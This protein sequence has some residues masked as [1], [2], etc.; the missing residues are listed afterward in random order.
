SN[1]IIQF[2]AIQFCFTKTLLF[3]YINT[4]RSSKIQI[5]KINRMG[6]NHICLTYFSI[7]E[8]S[9]SKFTLVTALLDIGRGNWWEYRRT[10]ENYYQYLDNILHLNVD[11]VIFLDDKSADYIYKRRRGLGFEQK[12]KII[13]ISF[14]E[15]PFY[16]YIHKA[17][18]IIKREQQGIFWDS[19]WDETMKHHPE[20]K[21]AIYN[22]LVNSKPYFL[23][24]I[25]IEN[26]FSARFMVWLDAGYGHGNRSIFPKNYEW[27]P[28]FLPNKISLIQVTPP[29][30]KIS[31]YTMADLYRKNWAVLSGG[32]IA[33]DIYALNRF[34]AY[35]YRVFAEMINQNR[36]DDDQTTMVLLV[37][38]HPQL[39]NIVHG[40]WFDAF[41]LF[42]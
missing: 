42:S 1:T 16:A 41:K 22:I 8:V 38:Q 7:A 15:L 24:K 20:G 31:R 23:Y 36:I 33:G 3:Y 2:S 25:S 21:S 34:Y 26:P 10:I 40:D 14:Y 5:K 29:H 13:P 19:N 39:F 4:F 35:Y 30:D 28:K 37:Q 32:F 11:L 12:T 27:K 9:T 17:E 6:S 18:E